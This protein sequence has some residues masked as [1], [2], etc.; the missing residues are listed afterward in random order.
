MDESLGGTI[1]IAVE[2]EQEK[3][4][5]DHCSSR[6]GCFGSAACQIW[7]Q[8][9]DSMGRCGCFDVSPYGIMTLS[10]QE[11]MGVSLGDFKAISESCH[12]CSGRQ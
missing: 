3:G 9:A 12:P 5:G 2:T 8:G 11:L 10:M 1:S 7:T 4:A 6:S